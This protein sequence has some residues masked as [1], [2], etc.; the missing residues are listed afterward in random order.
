MIAGSRKISPS[1]DGKGASGLGGLTKSVERSNSA[2]ESERESEESLMM[3]YAAGDQRAFTRLFGS[4]APRLHRFFFRSFRDRNVCDELLQTT[5]L[6][7][8]RARRDYRPGLALR[9]WIFT[10]AARIRQDELRRRYRLREDA[11]EEALA[12]AE[13]A[14]AAARAGDTDPELLAGDTVAKVR[15]AVEH[16]PESQRVVLELHRYQSLTFGEIAGILGTSE[17]AV[18]GRAFR[19]YAQ[20][21]KWLAPLWEGGAP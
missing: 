10:I 21:R 9:P 19:A 2:E 4:L 15:A 8:H 6:R 1:P 12:L 11:G 20:L 17:V 16:L 18:R 7:L 14:R 13:E 5:F 3:A